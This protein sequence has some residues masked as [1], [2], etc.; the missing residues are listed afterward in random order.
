MAAETGEPM[1]TDLPRNEDMAEAH[2]RP[3][4]DGQASLPNDNQ[5]QQQWFARIEY[6]F[7]QDIVRWRTTGR[8]LCDKLAAASIDKG[9]VSLNFCKAV[10]WSPDGTCVLTSTNDNKFRLF[11]NP[12]NAGWDATE[13]PSDVPL[14]PV[15]TIPEPEAV[16]DFAWY[17]Q[18]NSADPSTCCFLSTV[19]DHPIRLWD[20]YTGQMRASYTAFDHLDQV[21]APNSLT[22]NLDGTKMYCGSNNLIQIFDVHRPGSECIRRP[23]TPN[24]KSKEGQKG[25]ISSIAFNPDFSGMYAAGSY[26]G[27]VG[28][29]DERNDELLHQIILEKG[30]GLTQVEFSRDGT[31]LFYTSRKTN[32]IICRDLRNSGD[33]LATFARSGNTNQRIGF[34]LDPS[35]RCLSTGDD[36][37]HILVYD[38]QTKAMLKKFQAHNDTVSSAGFN[39]TLP[40]LASC[41]GQRRDVLLERVV[42]DDDGHVEYIDGADIS[43][44]ED[45]HDLGVNGARTPVDSSVALWQLPHEWISI[46]D[47]PETGDGQAKDPT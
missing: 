2:A 33:V 6:H 19:R 28:L 37:G 18:M 25:L 14:T 42:Y 39:P 13:S 36:T 41:S 34:S 40:L 27:S 5:Q 44:N 24:R 22:F 21:Q 20:A 9:G 1:Q 32:S 7:E 11:E 26:F 46:T 47:V 30:R 35:G 45:G 16:Y 17:P 29:Y 31:Q 4:T 15:L 12:A 43:D 8:T 38:L 23:T 3:T 10:E